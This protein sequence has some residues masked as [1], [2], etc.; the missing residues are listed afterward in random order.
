MAAP[1]AEEIREWSQVDFD[2]LGYGEDPA[3]QRLVNVALAVFT[4]WTGQSWSGDT[5][6]DIAPATGTEALA[7]DAIQ[8]LT[9][10]AAYRKQADRAETFGDFDLLSSFSAGGYSE[11]RRSGKDL[12]EVSLSQMEA[13]LWPLMTAAK[14]EEWKEMISG[15]N[16]PAFEVTSEDFG[17]PRDV[18]D[19][20][21]S[22][23]GMSDWMDA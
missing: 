6:S 16:A 14:Q 8:T 20:I 22:R 1:T 18:L 3:L 15:I 7:V 5:Y 2:S 12:R 23:D 17:I 11:S 13:M 19:P 21:V 10:I 4:R 9:E